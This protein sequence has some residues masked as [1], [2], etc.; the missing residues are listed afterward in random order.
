M[1]DILKYYNPGIDPY[2]DVEKKAF[3]DNR[4]NDID[5]EIK[6]VILFLNQLKGVFTQAS[7]AGHFILESQ[8]KLCSRTIEDLDNAYKFIPNLTLGEEYIDYSSPYISFLYTPEAEKI[9]L[10]FLRAGFNV[11][12]DK[13]THIVVS[14]FNSKIGWVYLLKMI[15]KWYKEMN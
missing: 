4:I 11:S 2:N 14:K 8:T 7:C 3:M 13:N 9:A 1:D 12:N 5:P 15:D 10:T 6:E